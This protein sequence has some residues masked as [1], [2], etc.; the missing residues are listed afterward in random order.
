[1]RQP[2]RGDCQVTV[3]LPCLDEAESVVA[4][5]E[6]ARL[7]LASAELVGEVLVV[8][9]GSTDGT[10]QLAADAGARV[11]HEAARGVGNAIRR[12]IEEAHG[13]IIV[14]ADADCTYE[15]SN[16][17]ALV[18]PVASGRAD[19][20][21]GYRDTKGDTLTPWTH[22]HLGTPL[23][24][25]INRMAAPGLAV[26][27]SQSGFRAFRRDEVLSLGLRTPGFEM[28]SEMLVRFA[29]QGYQIR[30]VP[31]VYRN[32]VGASKLSAV[33]D[34]LRH[35][36][37]LALLSPELL[38]RLPAM[39]LVLIGL[40][41]E[42][43]L[44]LRPNDAVVGEWQPVFLSTILVVIGALGWLAALAVR[45]ASPMAQVRY[46]PEVKA[47]DLRAALRRALAGGLGVLAAGACSELALALL[48][49]SAI[50]PTNRRLALASLAASCV[51]VGAVAAAT[52][53]IGLL[54]DWQRRH[55][56]DQP[57]P[58]GSAARN[59]AIRVQLPSTTGDR[60]DQ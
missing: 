47:E 1:M 52:S 17:G 10:A 12:G 45:H 13:P 26:R 24:S 21:I 14:M 9:N 22:H 6:E 38:L 57:L 27:D 11:I 51:L 49:E 15:L 29:G 59:N 28:C 4:C 36:R 2:E 33:R 41:M 58:H 5:I 16:L 7:G 18:E 35:L 20:V 39:V 54:V 30:E 48:S 42:S 60:R 40:T 43:L 34:G 44:I 19:L 23:L 50:E 56:G 46:D 3:V 25:W 53:A 31:T 37:I 55:L 8:D 32:R